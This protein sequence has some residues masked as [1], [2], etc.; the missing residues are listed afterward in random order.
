[1][2]FVGVRRVDRS[3]TG[4]IGQLLAPSRG[5]DALM[6]LP[7]VAAKVEGIAIALCRGDSRRIR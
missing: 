7:S 4:G 2:E 1:M 6:H 5:P 3:V